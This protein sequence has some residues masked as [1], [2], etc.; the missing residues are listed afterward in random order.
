MDASS[1]HAVDDEMEVSQSLARRRHRPSHANVRST[2]QR[3][4]RISKPLAVSERCNPPVG[5]AL[6]GGCNRLT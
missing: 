2:T 3:R 6:P 5:A 1:A 4:G